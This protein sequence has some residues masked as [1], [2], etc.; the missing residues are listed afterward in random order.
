MRDALAN[1]RLAFVQIKS[2]DAAGTA[3][4][5]PSSTEPTG[6][7]GVADARPSR[8]PRHLSRSQQRRPARAR[9]PAP[10]GPTELTHPPP[11]QVVVGASPGAADERATAREA[12]VVG[13]VAVARPPRPRPARGCT[14]TMRSLARSFIGPSGDG[15]RLRCRR[16]RSGRAWAAAS[17]STSV[18]TSMSRRAVG[19][20]RRSGTG[21][22]VP[23]SAGDVAEPD[24]LVEVGDRADRSRPSG[25]ILVIGSSRMSVAPAS[26]SAGMSSVDRPLLDDRS[27]W[28]SRRPGELD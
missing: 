26:L 12:G 21:T 25:T 15:H 16:P 5:R 1:I 8:A 2:R 14:S 20:R 10:A 27:R 28:R 19:D 22:R 13:D 7:A 11:R 3:E 18:P 23:S 4:P 24:R 9:G 17:N 6:E